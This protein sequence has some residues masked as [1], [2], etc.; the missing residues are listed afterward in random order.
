M[1]AILLFVRNK[2]AKLSNILLAISNTISPGVISCCFLTY[3]G[4]ASERFLFECCGLLD[5]LVPEDLILPDQGFD[6][7]VSVGTI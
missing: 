2:C 1:D 5:N 6:I 7:S 4:H 3:I